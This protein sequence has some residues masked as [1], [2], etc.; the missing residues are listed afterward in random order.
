[1]VRHRWRGR[2][3]PVL[4]ALLKF[5]TKP[6]IHSQRPVTSVIDAK[7]L[8]MEV[9]RYA[10]AV[11][12]MVAHAHIAPVGRSENPRVRKIEASWKFNERP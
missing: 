12:K 4:T 5:A 9:V 3:H 6:A 7:L 2:R 10:T 8:V 1:M 11:E